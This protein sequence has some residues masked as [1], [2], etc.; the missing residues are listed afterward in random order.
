MR[1]KSFPV[2]NRFLL[3]FNLSLNRTYQFNEM[4]VILQNMIIRS[5]ILP[6]RDAYRSTPDPRPGILQQA[7]GEGGLHSR[8]A[9]AR[10]HCAQAGAG[11]AARSLRDRHGGLECDQPGKHLLTPRRT[12]AFV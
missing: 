6:S 8:T 7:G 2:R 9:D 1:T 11:R 10:P 12:P 5:A 3:V 4:C